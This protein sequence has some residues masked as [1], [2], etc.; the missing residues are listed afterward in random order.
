MLA[1]GGIVVAARAAEMEY[2][3]NGVV[4]VGLDLALGGAITWISKSDDGL[5]VVNSCDWGREVQMS[6]YSGPAP[7]IPPGGHVAPQWQGLG[8]NPVQA[9]DAFGH[10]S[11]ILEH[12]NDGRT[13]YV[14]CIP[15][16]WPLEGAPSECTFQSWVDLDG[17]AIRVRAR[18]ENHRADATVYGARMQELPAVYT[19]PPFYRLLTYRGEHPFDG[20]PLETVEGKPPPGWGNCLATEHWMALVNDAGWGLG[21]WN[22]G[23]VRFICGFNGKP[24]PGGA[25]SASCGYIAP[26]REEILDHDIFHEYRYELILG[27]V[28]EI[29]ARVTSES[30]KSELPAWKFQSDRQGWIYHDAADAGW[31]VKGELQLTEVGKHPRLV[32]PE[33]FCRAE[34]APMMVIEAAFP[35]KEAEARLYWATLAEPKFAANR[36][37]PVVIHGDGEYQ[38]IRI[39]LGDASGYAGG[40][41]QLGLDVPAELPMKFRAVRFESRSPK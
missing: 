30:P 37:V 16:Q 23:C 9:G 38:E 26:I 24:G 17:P 20:E 33:F 2:L 32:S 35:A 4:R 8:W 41:V 13:L 27:S 5:N 31:P 25:D 10:R 36:S 14:R 29:R 1:T 28:E 19:N 11:Q 12:Q 3:D 15:M 21:I 34:A 7:F 22:P 18:L 6:Y 39:P 40:I